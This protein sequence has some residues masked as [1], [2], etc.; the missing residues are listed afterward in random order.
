MED[1][2][3]NLDDNA[4]ENMNVTMYEMFQAERIRVVCCAFKTYVHCSEKTVGR[5]CGQEPA[6]FTKKF[7][8]KMASSL[9]TVSRIF[10]DE[11]FPGVISTRRMHCGEYFKRSL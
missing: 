5:S 1:L 8:D 11:E 9:M 7:L 4:A 2:G 6:Q 3:R 10:G